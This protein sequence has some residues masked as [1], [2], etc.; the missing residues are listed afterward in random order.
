MSCSTRI[1]GLFGRVYV[2]KPLFVLVRVQWGVLMVCFGCLL[3]CNS[4]LVIC[5][6]ICGWVLL[7]IVLNM[8]GVVLVVLSMIC[9]DVLREV[10]VAV[11]YI[12]N[13]IGLWVNIFGMLF[14]YMWLL[15]FEEQFYFVWLVVLVLC[16]VF[17]CW[18]WGRD[19]DVLLIGVFFMV[20]VVSVF[21]RGAGVVGWSGLLEQCLDVF[22]FGVVVALVCCCWVL[23]WIVVVATS[24]MVRCVGVAVVWVG[25]VVVVGLVVLFW[26]L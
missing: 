8:V 22:V 23:V 14:G 4:R 24:A 20:F 18:V 7:F 3:R 21:L 15:V 26:L 13:W 6:R 16:F 11:I 2:L 12:C 19:V 17:W 10:V 5:R 1:I 9:Y 25:L